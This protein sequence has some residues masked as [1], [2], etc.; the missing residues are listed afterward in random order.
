MCAPSHFSVSAKR[1]QSRKLIPPW[2][3]AVRSSHR[4]PTDG[5]RDLSFLAPAPAHKINR[6]FELYNHDRHE[7][8]SVAPDGRSP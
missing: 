6:L 5:S 4:A 1:A 8:L 2:T 7:K 3:R